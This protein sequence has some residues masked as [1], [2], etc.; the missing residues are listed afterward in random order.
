MSKKVNVA[1]SFTKSDDPF[2]EKFFTVKRPRIDSE[3]IR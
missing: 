1:C 2:K 3:N